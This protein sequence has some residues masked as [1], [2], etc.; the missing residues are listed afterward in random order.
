MPAAHD[1]Q[2]TVKR[3]AA[4]LAALAPTLVGAH[5]A[6]PARSM[7][8]ATHVSTITLPDGS[9]HTLVT[10]ASVRAILYA[11]GLSTARFM[12]LGARGDIFVGSWSAGTVWV[13]L[14]RS[15]GT[16]ATRILMLLSELTV[17]R[18]SSLAPW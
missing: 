15:G 1:I 12:A 11:T 7:T 10:P 4:L 6:S 8:A 14:N 17:P 5:A 2:P 9:L 16:H 13:L 3:V 18:G